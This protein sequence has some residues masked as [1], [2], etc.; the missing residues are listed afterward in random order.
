V[1]LENLH[2]Y[3]YNVHCKQIIFGASA[4]NG[5][6][7]FLGSFLIDTDILS[8]IKLLKGQPFA[9]EFASIL[10]KLRWT[11]FTNVFRSE[12][13]ADVFTTSTHGRRVLIEQTHEQKRRDRDDFAMPLR[14]KA[15]T[16]PIDAF[17]NEPTI[18]AP[19]GTANGFE[20]G[21]HLRQDERDSDEGWDYE[22]PPI[23]D[24]PKP[25]L[26]SL[27]GSHPSPSEIEV[28]L[29]KA[30]I[31]RLNYSSRGLDFGNVKHDVELA[32][33]LSSDF[34]GKNEHDEWFLRSKNVIKKAVVSV[35]PTPL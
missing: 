10:P 17:V 16:K 32:L 19:W 8:R 35:S 2:L 27:S 18:S 24:S 14:P 30:T 33:G 34:W 13:L 23:P 6:A 26:S 20:G 1:D 21:I 25:V 15:A 9:Q 31:I 11:E 28:A 7:S 4:D 3:V 12:A 22:S 29:I 5:F